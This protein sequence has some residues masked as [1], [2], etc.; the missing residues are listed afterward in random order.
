V[1]LDSLVTGKY[2]LREVGE[3]L[4][5]GKNPASIKAVVYP[6]AGGLQQRYTPAT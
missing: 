1:D 3:A 4:R 6:R 2:D 5:V